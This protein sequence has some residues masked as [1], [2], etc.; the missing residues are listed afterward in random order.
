MTILLDYELNNLAELGRRCG[1]I[2]NCL[3]V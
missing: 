1:L 3:L 2:R